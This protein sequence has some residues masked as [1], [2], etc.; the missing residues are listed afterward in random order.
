MAGREGELGL[1]VAPL[2]F[3]DR[4]GP[5]TKRQRNVSHAAQW[6]IIHNLVQKFDLAAV[7]TQSIPPSRSP[8]LSLSLSVRV[9]VC[10]RWQLLAIRRPA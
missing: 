3:P 10:A 2:S 9:C 1:K 7:N 8:S 4:A 6:Q 5:D